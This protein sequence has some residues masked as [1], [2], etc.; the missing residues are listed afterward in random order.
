MVWTPTEPGRVRHGTE[1]LGLWHFGELKGTW[2]RAIRARVDALLFH[3]KGQGTV[4]NLVWFLVATCSRL[5]ARLQKASVGGLWLAGS[6][7]M[8]KSLVASR[9]VFRTLTPGSHQTNISQDFKI[10]VFDIT[11]RSM[12]AVLHFWGTIILWNGVAD[13]WHPVR[14]PEQ[15]IMLSLSRVTARKRPRN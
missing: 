1:L 15:G 3:D 13:D 8:D 5:T 14:S 10:L 6:T 11:Y 9:P 7:G 2:G 4:A 12:D